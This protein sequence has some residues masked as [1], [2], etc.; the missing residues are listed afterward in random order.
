M[1]VCSKADCSG[2]TGLQPLSNFNPRWKSNK[3]GK[4]YYHGICKL[5]RNKR[6]RERA[7][8]KRPRGAYARVIT[9]KAEPLAPMHKCPPLVR[10]MLTNKWS[11]KGLE[12]L[13][14]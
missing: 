7:A 3:T 12:E 10:L 8:A 9:P 6:D 13:N 11:V 4:Q 5:C 1:K 2:G 14:S